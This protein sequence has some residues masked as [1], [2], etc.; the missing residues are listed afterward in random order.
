MLFAVKHYI[1]R[2]NYK[3]KLQQI[4]LKVINYKQGVSDVFRWLTARK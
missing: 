2:L 4:Y 3:I 1:W